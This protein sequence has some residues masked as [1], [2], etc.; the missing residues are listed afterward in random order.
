MKKN[1]KKLFLISFIAISMLVIIPF[2]AEASLTLNQFIM[3]FIIGMFCII[4]IANEATKR[5]YSI[6]LIH[7]LF[8][9]FF[10]FLA[11]IVQIVNNYYPWKIYQSNSQIEKS[12]LFVILWIVVYSIF[13]RCFMKSKVKTNCDEADN[14][15]IE[16]KK[17]KKIQICNEVL[18]I[19]SILSLVSA[20]LIITNIGISNLFARSTASI[21]LNNKMWGLLL[22]HCTRAI[23]VFAFSVSLYNFSI[24]K[25]G[26]IYLLFNGLLLIITCFPTGLARNAAGTIYLGIYVLLH[27]GNLQKFKNSITYII[28]F[29]IAFVVVFPAINV[30]RRTEFS[31]V[32]VMEIISDTV[33]NISDNFLSGDYD[34]FSMIGNTEEHINKYG[35]TNGNQLLGSIFFF[36]PRNIWNSKPNGSGSLVFKTLNQPYINVACPLLAEGLINFGIIGI[37]IFSIIFASIAKFL[38]TRYWEIAENNEYDSLYLKLLYPFLLPSFFFMLRGDLQSTL[39]YMC[40]YIFIF[41]ILS[42]LFRLKIK[43]KI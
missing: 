5:A 8:V 6:N 37:I 41:Y 33:D 39:A 32:N 19:L 30:F 31:N 11:P 27:Y 1:A 21:E 14:N 18:I 38:D 43:S 20:L 24:N 34:A 17:I 4:N 40:A 35:T 15:I 7:W 9:F 25:K 16:N 36:I 23:I 10:F 28:I 3:F 12:C 13:Y 42:R 26:I 2:D 22:S 29:F